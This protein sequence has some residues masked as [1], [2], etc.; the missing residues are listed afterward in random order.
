[1]SETLPTFDELIDEIRVAVRASNFAL[2]RQRHLEA[3][4]MLESRPVQIGKNNT[5]LRYRDQ[6][7]NIDALITAAERAVKPGRL[8]TTELRLGRSG[9]PNTPR[10]RY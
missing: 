1:M 8:K 3:S 7:A 6:L 5:M 4:I 10:H 2:A 9:S